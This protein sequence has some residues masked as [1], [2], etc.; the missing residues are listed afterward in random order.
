LILEPY[1]PN[2]PAVLALLAR[3]RK[4]TA[5][6]IGVLARV[7]RATD[8]GCPVA[9]YAAR[10]PDRLRPLLFADHAAFAA[11]WERVEFE[12]GPP[13]IEQMTMWEAARDAVRSATMAAVLDE[14]LAESERDRLAHAWRTIVDPD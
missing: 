9:E 3:A 11:L 2:S 12:E 8:A 4:L 13:V 10:F 1:G 5:E 7:H 14:L 6:Q